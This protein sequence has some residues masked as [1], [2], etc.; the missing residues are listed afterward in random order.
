MGGLARKATIVDNLVNDGLE[1]L[2]LDSGNLFYK[3]DILDPGVE[4]ETAKINA[5]II[6][7][8]YNKIGCHAFSPGSF[9]FAAGYDNILALYNDSKFPFVSCNIVNAKDKLIF[10]PYVIIKR[11]KMK[12]GVIGL[13][14]IFE[15]NGIEV[16]NPIQALENIIDEVDNKTDFIVLLFNATDQDLN[17]LYNKNFNIDVI[18]KSK[19]RTRSSDGGSKIPTFIAGDRGKI[20]Y[21]ID[22]SILDK[23]LPLV[24]IAWCEN[25]ISR[26]NSRLEKMKKGDV[27]NSLYDIY[28]NDQTTLNRIKNYNNQIEKANNLLVNAINTISFEK[29]ELGKSIFDKPAILKII[30][31]GKVKIADLQSI[32]IENNLNGPQIIAPIGN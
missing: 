14:S 21:K 20:V 22:F 29:I 26:V 18:L 11:N 19:G 7:E 8:S 4:I 5:E 10:D 17:K 12:I 27:E 25:T 9:D 24:D 28:K 16:L 30:D 6:L 15:S 3:K 13:A 1:P 2:I 23:E 31:K 32:P